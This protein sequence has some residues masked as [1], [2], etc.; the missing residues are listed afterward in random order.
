M[1][2]THTDRCYRTNAAL[3]RFSSILER[4]L[5]PAG[6]FSWC[7]GPLG[8]SGGAVTIAGEP[9]IPSG[10]CQPASGAAGNTST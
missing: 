6:T 10:C 5:H 3:R 8:D 4:H 9:Q 7:E 2:H 1:G